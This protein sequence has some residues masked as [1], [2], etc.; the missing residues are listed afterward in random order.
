MRDEN[1]AQPFLNFLIFVCLK[2]RKQEMKLHCVG[3]KSVEGE[4][5]TCVGGA[6]EA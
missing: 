4:V 2:M 3:S 1:A 5:C 6:G